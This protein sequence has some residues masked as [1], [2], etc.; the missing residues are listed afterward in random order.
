MIISPALKIRKKIISFIRIQTSFY[1]SQNILF[2]TFWQNQISMNI[3]TSSWMLLH[4]TFKED[5][6]KS[7]DIFSSVIDKKSTS[8]LFPQILE[9]SR[10]EGIIAETSSVRSLYL[11]SDSL[12]FMPFSFLSLFIPCSCS[13]VQ[14]FWNNSR[15][16]AVIDVCRAI[17]GQAAPL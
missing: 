12:H 2:K 17:K 14:A 7:F 8:R 11:P 13:R 16:S 5:L 10:T 6:D 4:I 15:C 3:F 1:K 9:H